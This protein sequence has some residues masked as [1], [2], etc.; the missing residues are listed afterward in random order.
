MFRLVHDRELVLH[1]GS[2][3]LSS[4]KY[5]EMKQ[6][7]E[8]TERE[9]RDNGVL[10]IHPSFRIIALAEPPKPG[11]PNQQ[12]LNPE[13]LT[14]FMYHHMAPLTAENEMEIIQKM[15]SI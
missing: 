14:L 12:W 9:M 10:R 11:S 5:D 3:L 1:D 2:R 7:L 6:K 8:A 15:V 13:I 4:D